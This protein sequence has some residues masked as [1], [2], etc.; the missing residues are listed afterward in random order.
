MSV[1]DSFDIDHNEIIPKPQRFKAPWLICVIPVS[2][3]NNYAFCA[4]TVLIAL[5]ILFRRLFNN[6]AFCAQTVLIAPLI[7]FRRL[8]NNYAFCAQAVLI[9]PLI[10][11]RRLYAIFF[12]LA[13]EFFSFVLLSYRGHHISFPKYAIQHYVHKVDVFV[14]S[15]NL[16]DA[17][18]RLLQYC[19]DSLGCWDR[20]QFL[21][22]GEGQISF[23][24]SLGFLARLINWQASQALG[25][26]KLSKCAAS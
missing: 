26:S 19:V 22:R 3:F 1:R 20:W 25:R 12:F 15:C 23:I 5:L 6:Y 18:T 4:Q 8:F 9:A 2:L 17:W 16:A 7:L 10:L 13:T 11:F 21:R 24:Q 14:W